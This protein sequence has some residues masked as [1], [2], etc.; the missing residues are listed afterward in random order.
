VIHATLDRPTITLAECNAI[1]TV[2]PE[3][4][5]WMAH[6]IQFIQHG[7][8]DGIDDPI[9]RRKASRFTLV[10]GELYK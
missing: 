3:E 5:E 4:E 1:E 8:T 7:D 9:M 10:G 6:I 2:V